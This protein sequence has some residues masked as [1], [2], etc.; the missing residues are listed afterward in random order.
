MSLLTPSSAKGQPF[1]EGTA[2]FRTH[3]DSADNFAGGVYAHNP[4]EFSATECDELASTLLAV[5]D[6]LTAGAGALKVYNATGATLPK[7]TL[8]YIAGFNSGSA[9]CTIAK[10]DLSDPAKPPQLVLTA[11]LANAAS[12]VA[13][14]FA[15]VAGLDTSAAS[16]VGDKVFLAGTAGAFTFSAPANLDQELLEVGV[17]TVKDATNGAI[18]FLPGRTLRRKLSAAAL[19]GTT[20]S[21]STIGADQ[22]DYSP[23]GLAG[24]QLLRL[25]SS[26]AYNLTG[27]AA[28]FDRRVLFVH[29]AGSNAIV[30][31]DESS[32]S[33]AANRFALTADLSLAPDQFTL[34]QYDATSQRWR[35]LAGG[36]GSGLS[37]L[38]S[39]RIPRA[40]SGSSIAD[41]TLTDDGA[42]NLALPAAGSGAGSA[43]KLKGSDAGSGN[44]AGGDLVFEPGVKSGS[45]ADGKLIVRQ[46]GGTPGVDEVQISHDGTNLLFENLSVAGYN[47]F[48]S[49][50]GAAVFR[51]DGALLMLFDNLGRIIFSGSQGLLKNIT[52]GTNGQSLIGAEQA[53]YV[54]GGFYYYALT[55]AQ[56][57]A[58]QNDYFPGHSNFLRI[59]SN[60]SRDVTGLA[61]GTTFPGYVSMPLVLVNVGS[62]NI[63]FKH[64]SSGSSAANRLL[65]TTGADIT[66]GADQMLYCI[67]DGTTQRWRVSKLP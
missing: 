56:M 19:Q 64:Q 6:L 58:N 49:A 48:K 57:T 42:G 4:I 62:N 54:G 43:F 8:V 46:P 44:S 67:Y 13:Y 3:D 26:G 41:G 29:N 11:D 32:A 22:N 53:N 52:E 33:A 61:V 51:S 28:S 40:T 15:D 17:V 55:P 2:S 59:S 34:L 16:A 14:A 21:P 65:C 60:A 12:G 9:R 24:A 47:Q 31:K 20:L 1:V 27:L 38:T 7:G 35:A 63:V 23:A 45:G 5:V 10:A 36:G 39:S 30:F 66:L 25:A 50:F 37:G 18:R